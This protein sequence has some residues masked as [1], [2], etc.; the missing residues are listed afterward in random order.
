MWLFKNSYFDSPTHETPKLMWMSRKVRHF[1]L[2]N[3]KATVVRVIC[4]DSHFSACRFSDC[5]IF[6]FDNQWR[7]SNNWPFYD[8]GGPYAAFG[9]KDASRGLATFSVTA[10]EVEYDDLSDL[11]PPEMDSVREWEMQF[12]G[13]KILRS[14]CGE[15]KWMFGL[16]LQKNMTQLV[17]CWR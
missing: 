17:D 4:V 14:V 10:S 5:L 15:F 3:K 8:Q 7:F 6:P 1:S 12:K 9:G 13:E 16:C 2:E 11:T